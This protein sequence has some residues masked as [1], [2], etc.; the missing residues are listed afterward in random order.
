MFSRR[1]SYRNG[2]VPAPRLPSGRGRAIVALS[3]ALILSAL[4]VFTLEWADRTFPP[5]LS[6]ADTVSA[7]VLDRDG[8][9]LRA[10]AAKDGLWRLKTTAQD[11]D[12]RFIE[13]LI[14][15]EDQRFREHHGSTR[16]RSLVPRC[17]SSPTA[18]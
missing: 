17:N 16:W 5:P 3:L 11:V 6:E 18:V 1:K 2:I 8:R 12:P 13:M 7:E 14:A 10:F 9:L 4:A 15:Y